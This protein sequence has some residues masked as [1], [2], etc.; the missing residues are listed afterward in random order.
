MLEKF[1]VVHLALPMG[2][3]GR[4]LE[5]VADAVADTRGGL[6]AYMDDN[7]EFVEV[8]G[9]MLAAW[10]SGIAEVLSSRT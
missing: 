4:I 3:A 1:A 5:E 9:K 10:E 6:S 2:K 8:G 7:P